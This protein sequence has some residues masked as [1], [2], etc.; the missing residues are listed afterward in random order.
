MDTSPW[1][2][3]LLVR[4]RWPAITLRALSAAA[5]L[6]AL[7]AAPSQLFAADVAVEKAGSQGLEEVVVTAQYR[8]EK[9]QD[10]PIAISVINADDIQQR[11]SPS[12]TKLATRCPTCHSG[13]LKPRLATL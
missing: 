11:P 9:L 12:H 6:L 2:G 4:G 5:A 13:P 7:V 8:Q 1:N 3:M 10:T